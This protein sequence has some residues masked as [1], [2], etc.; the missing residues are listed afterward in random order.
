LL[1]S[2]ADPGL[3]IKSVVS[4]KPD[5]L[6]VNPLVTMSSTSYLLVGLKKGSATLT[7]TASNGK[8]A[9]KKITVRDKVYIKSFSFYAADTSSG[10]PT[11]A[12]F[13]ELTF[14]AGDTSKTFC[15]YAAAQP[16]SASFGGD[17]TIAT[18]IV[19]PGAATFSSSSPQVA[20]VSERARDGYS[21]VLVSKPGTAT[22]TVQ[23]TDGG[24]AKSTFKVTAKG[25]LIT[26]FERVA[27]FSLQPGATRHL[28][29]DAVP[30][31]A[32]DKTFAWSSSN[33]KVAAVDAEGNVTAVRLGTSTITCKNAASGLKH[34]FKVTVGY[35]SVASGT[36]YRFFAYN[37][38]NM[39]N[40]DIP[41]NSS[42]LMFY[43]FG[44]AFENARLFQIATYNQIALKLNDLHNGGMDEDD[45]TVIYL[46][47]DGYFAPGSE[48]NGALCNRFD[49]NDRLTVAQVRTILEKIP[50]T[51]ILIV[52][53]D[54][55]GSFITS[56]GAASKA[57]ALARQN[58][59]N[60]VWTDAFSSSR[61]V[62]YSAKGLADSEKKS[63][64][65]ILTACSATGISQIDQTNKA[66][67][68]SW[69]AYW[70]AKGL[71]ATFGSDGLWNDYTTF[72]P[73]TAPAN[74]NPKVDKVIT[75]SELYKYIQAGI[76]S[77]STP[78]KWQ[79]VSV[80]PANDPTAVINMTPYA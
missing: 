26:D 27:D 19:T 8:V 35:N 57:Q 60:R 75:L 34:S 68:Y 44:T 74:A 61:A 72:T 28:E 17:L 62:N 55:S 46:T 66:N 25:K 43:S 3:T 1:I 48:D 70:L 67:Q 30:S 13:K 52:D 45:V 64:F 23:A 32:W 37:P 7:V 41:N 18:D 71:G 31:D 11:A 78:L 9:K 50:G 12:S 47:G 4:D 22:L 39:V 36:T 38:V 20:L 40:T 51:V 73:A 76:K 63:K 16:T 10:A 56:K 59:F 80:W 14:A 79:T 58:A 15:L 42:W 69:F 77:E 49:F 54:C 24:K 6:Y 65:K 21:Q 5:V 33:K 53:A 29:P 2:T